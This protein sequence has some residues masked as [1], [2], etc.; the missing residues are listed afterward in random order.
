MEQR[1]SAITLGVGSLVISKEFYVNGLGW[2]PSFEDKNI[3]FFQAGGLVF[4]LY[5]REELA[6][7]FHDEAVAGGPGAFA[8]AHNV[9]AKNEVDP[10]FQRALAAGA[11]PLKPP[12]EAFWGGYSGYFADP[13]GFVWEIAWNPNWPIA[14]DGTIELC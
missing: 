10:L 13:D 11:T 6:K 2:E 7:D 5:V 3:V 1:I 9:R 12:Q 14:R 4:G 8:L